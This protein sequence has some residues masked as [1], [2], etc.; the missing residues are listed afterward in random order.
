MGFIRKRAG[1]GAG[2]GASAGKGHMGG[3]SKGTRSRLSR[4]HIHAQDADMFGR[5]VEV[6]AEEEA[7]QGKLAVDRP[8]SKAGHERAIGSPAPSGVG[9]K[10]V[11]GAGGSDARA[12]ARMRRSSMRRS[13]TSHK[14]SVPAPPKP[15]FKV[16]RRE[17]AC[18]W[19]LAC[20]SGVGQLGEAQDSV[21]EHVQH[22]VGLWVH[23]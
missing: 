3:G 4:V 19:L 11:R 7:T 15:S 1:A 18:V 13:S 17:Q 22:L 9:K 16:E 6:L 5:L 8:V 21:M 12:E 20:R 14:K 10:E 23:V 2:A